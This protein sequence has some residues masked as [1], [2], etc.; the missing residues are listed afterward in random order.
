MLSGEQLRSFSVE[1][2]WS[3][4]QAE[5]HIPE[6]LGGWEYENSI[7]P[8]VNP[9]PRRNEISILLDELFQIAPGEDAG[10]DQISWDKLDEATDKVV[11]APGDLFL[12]AHWYT[13]R[14]RAQRNPTTL[15]P[16]GLKCLE[17]FVSA[18]LYNYALK[19]STRW[20]L[21]MGQKTGQVSTES[22]RL[23]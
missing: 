7:P 15:T 13:A 5:L 9:P 10:F 14:W 6:A 16:Q 1:K 2:P 12:T 17:C 8:L 20:V 23:Y 3:K 18:E 21:P 22:V 11:I 19:I 4:L